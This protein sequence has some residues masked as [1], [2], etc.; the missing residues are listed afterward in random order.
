MKKETGVE[1]L[2]ECITDSRNPKIYE[3]AQQK[4]MDVMED[5]SK[6]LANKKYVLS[7]VSSMWRKNLKGNP[8]RMSELYKMFLESKEV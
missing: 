8:K 1:Y 2:M 7:H 3:I 5:F 4:Q 6:W